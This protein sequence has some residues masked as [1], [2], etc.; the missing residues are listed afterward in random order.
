MNNLPEESLLRS[1]NMLKASCC[2]LASSSSIALTFILKRPC[3]FLSL[4]VCNLLLKMKNKSAD[5]LR[6][7]R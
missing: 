4:N 6:L 1:N 7:L 3:R 5:I 2:E